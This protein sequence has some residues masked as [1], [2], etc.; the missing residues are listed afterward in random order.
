MYINIYEKTAADVIVI[1]NTQIPL[2]QEMFAL[3]F[4]FLLSV[5][6]TQKTDV[7]PNIKKTN[8]VE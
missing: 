8:I 1:I 6:M 4:H 7:I 2:I 5:Q 3:F